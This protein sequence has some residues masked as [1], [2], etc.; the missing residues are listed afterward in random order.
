MLVML[1]A[2]K[3]APCEFVLDK[4]W[5]FEMENARCVEVMQINA[6]PPMTNAG[7]SSLRDAKMIATGTNAL[8]RISHFKAASI[9]SNLSS[10]VARRCLSTRMKEGHVCV[11]MGI[12][13]KKKGGGEFLSKVCVV[14]G[15]GHKKMDEVFMY[16]H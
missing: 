3:A 5:R 7:V 10:A 2:Y 1:I 16:S 6:S 12:G 9:R 14:M 15:I 8:H 13:H 4:N 11:V